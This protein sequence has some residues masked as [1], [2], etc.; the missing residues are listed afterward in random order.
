MAVSRMPSRHRI[1]TTSSGRPGS[2][3]STTRAHRSET[4]TPG[5]ERPRGHPMTRRR[6]RSRPL[7]PHAVVAR[8]LQGWQNPPSDTGSVRGQGTTCEPEVV[9]LCEVSEVQFG[10]ERC[11]REDRIPLQVMLRECSG[12]SRVPSL[13]SA[14]APPLTRPPLS[15]SW[16]LWGMRRSRLRRGRQTGGPSTFPHLLAGACEGARRFLPDASGA[17]T[18]ESA[19]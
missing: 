6:G 5:R 1:E 4:P 16:R 2:K 9:P 12:A 19:R 11:S 7:C 3:S 15:P 10:L 13:R 18:G 8:A 17:C 14:A